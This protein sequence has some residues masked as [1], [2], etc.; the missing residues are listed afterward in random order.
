MQRRYSRGERIGCGQ[1]KKKRREGKRTLSL[2][3]EL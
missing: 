1:F 3:G 2:G